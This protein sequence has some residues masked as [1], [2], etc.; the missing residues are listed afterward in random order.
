MSYVRAGVEVPLL[1]NRKAL[2][3]RR[4]GNQ[5]KAE[6]LLKEKGTSALPERKTNP[7]ED[8]KESAKRELKEETGIE[9]GNLELVSMTN[10]KVPDAHFVTTRFLCKEF[11]GEPEARE[12]EQ[13]VEWDWFPPDN[14]PEP[15]SPPS[16][17]SIKNY[18]DR[19]VH[20]H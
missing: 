20:E 14:L 2:P 19:E 13:I 3:G 15:V 5:K 18:K 9:A 10:D 8:I 11:G 6:P 17:K 4:H 16:S 12:P 7:H 1:N